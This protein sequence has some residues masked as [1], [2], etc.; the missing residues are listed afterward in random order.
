MNR[1]KGGKIVAVWGCEGEEPKQPSLDQ[2]QLSS[3]SPTPSRPEFGTIGHCSTADG[4]D[5]SRLEF[6]KQAVSCAFFTLLL[7]KNLTF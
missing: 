4:V 3:R 1:L 6:E 5:L 7:I 2:I